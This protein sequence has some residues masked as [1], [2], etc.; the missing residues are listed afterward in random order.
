MSSAQSRKPNLFIVGA[1]KCGTTAWYEYLRSHPH[2]FM[3]VP[4]EPTF[5][6]LD[7]PNWRKIRSEEEYRKLYAHSG[8]AKVVGEASTTYL[9]SAT[10]ANAIRASNPEAKILIF[11]RDQAEYL[12]SLH[13]QY[14]AE[15]QEDITDFETAWRLSGR[16]PLEMIPPGCLEPRMLDYAAM[17]RFD[18]QVRRYFDVFPAE[19]I[20]VYWFDEWVDDPRST[21]LEILSFLGL[22]DDGRTEFQPANRGI[23]LRFRPLVRYLDDPPPMVRKVARL[24]KRVTGLKAETQQKLVERTVEV[25]TSA[26]YKDI[27]PQLRDEI[28]RH[29][30]VGNRRLNEML[31]S[32]RTHA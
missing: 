15:F 23:T 16:R 2:I 27:S 21:Y 5:F 7:V 30:A 18:E 24:F 14:L 6:A 28:R 9:V 31:A 25:L 11:L 3:S 10:A 17:G 4:K 8:T 19:Q 29:F 20:R 1:M 32:T 22:R 13:S 26:G 12:P